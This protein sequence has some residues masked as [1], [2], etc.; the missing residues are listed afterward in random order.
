ML[1][2]SHSTIPLQKIPNQPYCE[3]A[4]KLVLTGLQGKHAM[5]PPVHSIMLLLPKKNKRDKNSERGEK[6][7]KRKVIYITS[8]FCSEYYFGVSVKEIFLDQK[9]IVIERSRKD[10][11][12]RKTLKRKY[13]KS[14]KEDE[15]TKK[16]VYNYIYIYFFF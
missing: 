5:L 16:G 10:Y 15:E 12:L 4:A 7:R 8:I 14:K 13:F 11:F 2:P 6:R 9:V 1:Q 3:T